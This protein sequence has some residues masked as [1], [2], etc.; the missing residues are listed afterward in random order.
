MAISN[1]TTEAVHHYDASID[2]TYPLTTLI[3]DQSHDY[4]IVDRAEQI[5]IKQ[6]VST[7]GK[8]Q[9]KQAASDLKNDLPVE[10]QRSMAISS[11][12]GSSN[13]LSSLPIS[14]FGFTFHKGAFR[15]AVCLR[16]GW[17]PANLPTNCVCGKK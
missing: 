12:K 4:S 11:E 16:Y 2:I 9:L 13:W 17:T 10:M 7:N 3:L 6:Q 14:E 15:D 8:A 1:P 5:E